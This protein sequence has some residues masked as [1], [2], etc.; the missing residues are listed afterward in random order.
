M[1]IFKEVFKFEEEFQCNSWDAFEDDFRS[2]NTQSKL[3]IND[4]DFENI[5]SIHLIIKNT[6]DFANNAKQDYFTFVEILAD[7]TEKSRY[8]GYNFSFELDN[9]KLK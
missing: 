6:L 8:D 1:L 5:T 2:L 4:P 3:I 9:S 7:A